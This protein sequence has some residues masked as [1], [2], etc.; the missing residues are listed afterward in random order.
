[1]PP[2]YSIISFGGGR[3]GCPGETVIWN[4]LYWERKSSFLLLFLLI[5]FY[6]LC[7]RVRFCRLSLACSRSRRSCPY[8]CVVSTSSLKAQSS[9]NPITRRWSL[10][11]KRLSKSATSRATPSD[12][13]KKLKD[14]K[15][16]NEK[17]RKGR[18]KVK[19]NFIKQLLCDTN[20]I[21]SLIDIDA[22]HMTLRPALRSEL[23]TRPRRL[24]SVSQSKCSQ[25]NAFV[26]SRRQHGH[27]NA[28]A[29]IK[30]CAR[31]TAASS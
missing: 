10:V 13:R 12:R 27:S 26:I 21:H 19:Q 25:N 28:S 1:M 24:R 30:R 8:C 29:G 5:L 3:H 16:E 6:C 15:N 11:R 20:L 4:F 9:P 22:C 31:C 2:K 14:A 17:A 7:S 18:K 23:W